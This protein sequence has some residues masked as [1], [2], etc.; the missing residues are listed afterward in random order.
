MKT[1]YIYISFI[2]YFFKA[3]FNLHKVLFFYH[4]QE[5]AKNKFKLFGKQYM[6][7]ERLERKDK[8]PK[9]K[10]VQYITTLSKSFLP[11]NENKLEDMFLLTMYTILW[12]IHKKENIQNE[13]SK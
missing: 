1:I 2:F 13:N 7:E 3:F 4:S 10:T 5:G 12:Y 9:T 6:K 8:K 11:N